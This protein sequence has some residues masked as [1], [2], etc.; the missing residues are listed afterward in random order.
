MSEI[1]LE[2]TGMTCNH[3]V[4]HTKEKLEAVAGVESVEVTLEPGGAVVRGNANAEDLLAA[5][6]EAGYEARVV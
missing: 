4:A 1:K 5:V 3:C 2:I 6:K